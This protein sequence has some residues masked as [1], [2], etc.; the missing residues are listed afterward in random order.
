MFVVDD[1]AV[2]SCESLVCFQHGGDSKT[3][4]TKAKKNKRDGIDPDC[5][6]EIVNEDR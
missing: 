6:F 3:I 4:V 2:F 5:C 1:T